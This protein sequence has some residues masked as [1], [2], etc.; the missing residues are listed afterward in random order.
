LDQKS[1]ANI[2]DYG[3]LFRVQTKNAPLNA[4]TYADYPLRARVVNGFAEFDF[5]IYDVGLTQ[6]SA[7]DLDVEVRAVGR[8]NRRG[9]K[10]RFRIQAEPS[11]RP[12]GV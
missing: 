1:T 10:S 12:D 7:I 3:Y 8:T 6:Q 4:F 2:A 9:P 5:D 11:K